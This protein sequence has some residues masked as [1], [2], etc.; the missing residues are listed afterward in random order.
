MFA[1]RILDPVLEVAK[2]IRHIELDRG[3]R[4]SAQPTSE[5]VFLL[6]Q[7]SHMTTL[8]CQAGTCNAGRART[9][10]RYSLRCFRWR[11]HKWKSVLKSGS[12]IDR[13]LNMAA[14]DNLVEAALLVANTGHNFFRPAC[15]SFARPIGIRKQW[16]SEHDHIAEPVAKRFLGNIGVA[17]FTYRDDRNWT[18]SIRLDGVA[19][20]E[21]LNQLGY[22]QKRARGHWTWRVWQP[23]V[24]VTAE[25]HIHNVYP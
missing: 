9:D 7:N 24:L 12:R 21:T 23:P 5:L 19:V 15:K 3:R 10:H 25:I 6:K 4:A 20:D 11:W 1:C 2:I 16:P 18:T 13:T 14:S 8:R 22:K 17:Q